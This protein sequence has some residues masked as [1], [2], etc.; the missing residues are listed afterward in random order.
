MRPSWILSDEER[1]RRFHG[2][3]LQGRAEK[4]T[5]GRGRKPKQEKT[6]PKSSSKGSDTE[7]PMSLDEDLPSSVEARSSPDSVASLSLLP[8]T[9][10]K[11]DLRGL[12]QLFRRVCTGRHDDLDSSL[13]TDLLQ[14]TLHGTSLSVATASQL[15]E[16]IDSRSRACLQLLPEFRALS[17]RDQAAILAHNLPL[18]HRFRQALCLHT[19]SWS[20]FIREL[21]GEEKIKQEEENLPTDLSGS[22][23]KTLAYRDLFSFPWCQSEEVENIHKTMMEDIASWVDIKDEVQLILLALILAFNHDFLDLE[24]RGQVEKIQLKYVIL[25]QTHLRTKYPTNLAASKLTKAV[26]LP[27][28][29]R[30]ILQITKKRLNI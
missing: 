1:V 21:I 20:D 9:E 24:G 5:T 23:K 12:G 3:T 17:P 4:G 28:V 11:V 22:P 13:L 29:T 18:I 16:V 30:E 6:S 26:M 14:V 7:E 27:A 15:S 8:V 19:L 10:D 2:R 25:L